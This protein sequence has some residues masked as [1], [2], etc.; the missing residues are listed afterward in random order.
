MSGTS[1]IRPEVIDLTGDDDELLIVDHINND[2]IDLTDDTDEPEI[3]IDL[4]KD[5]ERIN[6]DCDDDDDDDGYD[7]SYYYDYGD[8]D[9][10]A[11]MDDDDETDSVYLPNIYNANQV[12]VRTN[13]GIYNYF[14]ARFDTYKLIITP[15]FSFL[16][17]II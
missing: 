16:L 15:T 8:G 17:Q 12:N 10:D 2:V 14:I 11:N 13:N 9:E 1:L 7:D 4:T 3:V 6:M 5:T